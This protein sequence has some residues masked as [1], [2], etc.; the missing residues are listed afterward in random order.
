[1]T[2]RNWVRPLAAVTLTMMG[3]SAPAGATTPVATAALPST[4]AGQLMR[5]WMT[6]CAAPNLTRL[7]QW[8]AENLSPENIGRMSADDQ[9]QWYFEFCASNHGLRVTEV[10]Q[11]DGKSMS[12]V[13][14]R[15]NRMSGLARRLRRTT[16]GGSIEL[17]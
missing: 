2:D 9:A 13:M 8:T 17:P 5:S 12:L 4:S 16:R 11:S 3:W 15:Q 6:V 1:M 7:R 10:T 14:V